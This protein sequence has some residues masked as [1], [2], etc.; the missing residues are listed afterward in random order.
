MIPVALEKV[1]NSRRFIRSGI[2]RFSR[3]AK[4]AAVL[5]FQQLITRPY[6]L[7]GPRTSSTTRQYGG[8]INFRDV[9][10]I[11]L[12]RG[13]KLTKSAVLLNGK[14]TVPS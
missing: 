2:Q 6:R 11:P 4:L 1:T 7:P 14:R 5:N 13:N 8:M 3:Q 9:K 12:Y 10:R